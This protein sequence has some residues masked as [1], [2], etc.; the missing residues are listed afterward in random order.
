[1]S[2]VLKKRRRRKDYQNK[3]FNNPFFKDKRRGRTG[4]SK[5]FILYSL[6]I[7][8]ILA[9]AFWFFYISDTFKIKNIEINGL[10]RTAEHEVLDK[11]S[12]VSGKTKLFLQQDNLFLISTNN[13]STVL[14]NHF[15]FA[16]V[17]INKELPGKIIIDISER[18]YEAIFLEDGN[19]YYIDK[20]GYIVDK[21]NELKDV[22]SVNYAII[23]NESNNKI[24]ENKVS[25]ESD[26]IVFIDNFFND[27][28]QRSSDIVIEKFI[29]KNINSGL[30]AQVVNGPIL[31]L[32]INN[33]VG[34]Q[35]RNLVILKENKLNDN[36]FQRSYIDLRYGNRL[37]LN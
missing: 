10:E 12:E 20:A 2:R 1:M 7:I 19:Y 25:I 23:N 4:V 33:E 16:Q 36:F 35:V 32:N 27:L 13:L 9:F 37:F 30:S 15:N 17:D 29:V 6:V 21:I 8:L 34:S 26:Y 28:K 3:S 22:N 24:E 14:K 5:K 18:K 11:I 31:Y